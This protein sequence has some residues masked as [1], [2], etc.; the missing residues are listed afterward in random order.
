MLDLNLNDLIERS[1]KEDVGTGDITTL[2]TIDAKKEITGR[3]IA[4][5]DGILCGMDVIRVFSEAF[6]CSAPIFI[7]NAESITRTDFG[8]ASQVIRLVVTPGA[9]TL[10][11]VAEGPAR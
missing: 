7:D 5:E 6:E 8:T 11:T 10:N 4:K 3:F 1:L 9:D 2:S